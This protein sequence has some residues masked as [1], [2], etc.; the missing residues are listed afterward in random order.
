MCVCVAGKT[1]DCIPAWEGLICIL[2]VFSTFAGANYFHL[3]RVGSTKRNF[4]R[5]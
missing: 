4:L 3:E 5:Q 1:E 2:L